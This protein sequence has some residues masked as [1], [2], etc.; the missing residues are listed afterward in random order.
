[1]HIRTGT[2][3][4][5]AALAAFAARTFADAFAAD[6]T[7]EDM[8]AHAARSY[9]LAQQSA[10]LTNPD[11][12]TLLVEQDAQLVAYAQLRRA[13]P[14]ACVVATT[15]LELHRFYVDRASHG[16][17]VAQQLMAAVQEAAR[18]AGARHL[19]LAVWERNP[20]AI[21]FY[22]KCGFVDVG[23]QGFVLGSN[24]QTGR[25]M[26]APVPNR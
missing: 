11:A 12:V 9:G 15:L 7:P 21:R 25:V 24:R 10:E 17:G 26:V 5:A 20:R 1:V 6:N 2:T 22:A 4:D 3:A 18:A 14:P 19:W 23:S 13:T 8:H 16:A